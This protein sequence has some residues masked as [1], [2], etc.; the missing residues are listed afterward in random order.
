MES[1]DVTYSFACVCNTNYIENTVVCLE[2]FFEHNS[3]PVDVYMVNSEKTNA[4]DRFDLVR[5]HY[6]YYAID[7]RLYTFTRYRKC[8]EEIAF[9]FAIMDQMTTDYLVIFD[10][11]T[12]F[13]DSIDDVLL[14]YPTTLNVV[15]NR[16]FDGI[17]AG[18]IIYKRNPKKLFDRFMKDIIEGVRYDL[19][20]EEFMYKIFKDDITFLDSRFNYCEWMVPTESKPA[21]IHYIGPFKPFKMFDKLIP[22][23][24]TTK[25]F[26]MYYEFVD[27]H[28]DIVSEDFKRTLKS[29][30]R[31]SKLI[32]KVKE[33]D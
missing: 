20:E 9:R 3:I 10:T 19:L 17:N 24:F 18:F 23:T 27:K 29:T 13:V 32:N 4:F 12:L 14:E 21:M 26:D 15:K 7:R 25:Y 6:T 1:S 11:D 30:K 5:V 2:S 22:G 31:F 8:L 16:F 33:R 28:Q